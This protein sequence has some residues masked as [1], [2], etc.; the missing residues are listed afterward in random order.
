[1]AFL[2]CQQNSLSLS[3]RRALSPH[4]VLRRGDL[5]V[6]T[7]N[8]RL[9]ALGFLASSTQGSALAVSSPSSLSF[10]LCLLFSFFFS[11]F[12]FLYFTTSLATVL[13]VLLYVYCVL[14]TVY[15][16]LGTVSG[17]TVD[18]VL[19]TVLCTVYRTRCR[20][21]DSLFAPSRP[22]WL[23][24]ARKQTNK[25][26][27]KQTTKQTTKQPNNQTNK[28]AHTHT[29]RHHWELWAA[30]PATRSAVG[31]RQYRAGYRVASLAWV[32]EKR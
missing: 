14:C 18:W 17:G 7:V 3:D 10:F 21:D 6:V 15:C 31:A 13:A 8:Y 29:S 25:Q 5:I 19:R 9:G 22:V 23:L 4:K 28:H 2:Y 1:M 20:H 32:G 12:L 30:G 24:I 11:L 26:T 16:V 27:N